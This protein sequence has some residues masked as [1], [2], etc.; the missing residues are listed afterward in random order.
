MSSLTILMLTLPNKSKC[1]S[2]V[3]VGA[4]EDENVVFVVGEHL[5]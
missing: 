4:D 1:D 2:S 5:S 3:P